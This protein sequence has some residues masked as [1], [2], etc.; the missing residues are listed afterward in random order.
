MLC[1]PLAFYK[2][3]DGITCGTRLIVSSS[4]RL[5]ETRCYL[6]S[7]G[8]GH[9]VGKKMATIVDLVAHVHCVPFCS[10]SYRQGFCWLCSQ[11][12]HKKVRSPSRPVVTRRSSVLRSEMESQEHCSQKVHVRSCYLIF[13]SAFGDE[14]ASR[15]CP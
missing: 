3:W 14:E 7:R 8:P 2:A 13:R 15:I 6:R 1:A 11:S 5:K 12:C 4:V 10:V 9:R